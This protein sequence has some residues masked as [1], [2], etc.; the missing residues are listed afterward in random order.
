MASFTNGKPFV[1]TEENC[2]APWGCGKNGKYFRCGFCGHK[3]VPGDIV[4][5][6]YTNNVSGADGNP[7]VCKECD[8]ED[9]AVVVEKWRALCKEFQSEKFWWFR[10]E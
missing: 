7:L 4:R 1:A 6:Q 2:K 5:W 3:F 9:R 8:D 10:R